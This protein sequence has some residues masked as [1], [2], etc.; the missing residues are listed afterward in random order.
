VRQVL[1]RAMGL[2][3]ILLQV[4]PL[5]WNIRFFV[6]LKKGQPLL[7]LLCAKVQVAQLM[8][9]LVTLQLVTKRG[10]RRILFLQAFHLIDITTLCDKLWQSHGFQQG[11]RSLFPIE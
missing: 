2:V 5:L 3:R 7:P 9:I 10:W 4:M 1:R 11:G 6:E 8:L